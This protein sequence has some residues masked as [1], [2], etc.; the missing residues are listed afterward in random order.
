MRI[1]KI[2]NRIPGRIPNRSP[3]MVF[4]SVV[5][6]AVLLA[7]ALFLVS[8]G[9]D[10]DSDGDMAAAEGAC[11]DCHNP[12]TE[13]TGRAT[14]WADSVHGTGTAYVRAASA[15]C[16]GC[17]SGGAFSA[18]MAAGIQNPEDVEMGDPN[19]TRQD[20]RACHQI[21]ETYSEADWALETTAAVP[22]YAFTDVTYDGGEGNLCATCHQPRRAFPEATDGMVE[23]DS[24]HWGTHH[25]PMTA[26]LLGVGGAGDV[27]GSTGPHYSMVEDTCVTCHL[28]DDASH[29]FLPNVAA[30]VTCHSDAEDFD[31]GGV[32][33]E[34]Q[35]MLD[36]LQAALMAAG[37]LDEEG[38]IVVGTYPE[39]QAAALWNWIYVGTED[40]SEGVHNP[41]YAKALLQAGLDALPEVPAP[42]PA[43]EAPAAH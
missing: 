17:H 23:V 40:K 33:T 8:C 32:Q 10:S 16:A 1:V 35:G 36:H 2:P 19:P 4:L 3:I 34:V 5:G 14:A 13:L 12:G 21:H 31:I 24:T 6:L 30:C 15:D 9:S 37:L 18:M 29:T 22:L 38:G 11:A 28:G 25:G 42:A 20:C 41:S 39:A 27:T 26:M 7:A 43:E